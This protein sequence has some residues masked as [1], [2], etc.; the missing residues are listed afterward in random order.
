MTFSLSALRQ[1]LRSIALL[2][3]PYFFMLILVLLLGTQFTEL[4]TSNEILSFS[5]FITL[6]S[7]SALAFNWSR[8]STSFTSEALLR[9][10][11][12]SGI[13][14]FLASLLALIATFF[15]WLLTKPG[16]LVPFSRTIQ[17]ILFVLHW[18]FLALSLLLF[19]LALFQL[20]GTTKEIFRE[21]PLKSHD[22]R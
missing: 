21:A 8:V 9:S 10:I 4:G 12:R 20:L 1:S 6:I 14:L 19:L 13:D 11:Y 22:E 15:A 2:L 7:M 5:S 18:I 3:I 17:I 16:M